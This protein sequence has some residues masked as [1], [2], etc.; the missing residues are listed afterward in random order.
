MPYIVEPQILIRFGTAVLVSHGV[1]RPDAHLLSDSL[2]TAELWG[3]S[4]HGIL[5]SVVRG[6][7]SGVMSAI[8]ASE[9][10]VDSEPWWS[11]TVTTASGKYSLRMLST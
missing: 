3:H 4:S 6:T 9:T 7:R 2:V 11:S 8:T 10:V 1:P 5:P